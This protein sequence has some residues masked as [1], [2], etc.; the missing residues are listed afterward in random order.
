VEKMKIYNLNKKSN[1]VIS[2]IIK[3]PYSIEKQSKLINQII[4]AYAICYS[5]NL[6]QNKIKKY[7]FGDENEN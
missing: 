6:V 4:M 7:L 5:L 2:E 1:K 3:R